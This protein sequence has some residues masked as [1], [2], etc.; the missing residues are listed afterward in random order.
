MVIKVSEISEEGLELDFEIKLEGMDARASASL[1]LQRAGFVVYVSGNVTARIPLECGRCLGAFEADISIPL[2]IALAAEDD[3]EDGGEEEVE[4]S[5]DNL[6]R[7]FLGDEIDLGHMVEEQVMLNLPM[8]PL[9]SEDCKGLCPS[10]GADLNNVE[11]GCQR[12]SVDPRL[13]VL[14]KLLNK[15]EKSNG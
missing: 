15:G 1:T 14:K 10:C 11:C 5:A 8:K 3:T 7:Q 9:C 2:D 12:E 4:L 13:Q 6:T